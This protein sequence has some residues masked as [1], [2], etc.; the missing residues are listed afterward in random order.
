MPEQHL[1][2]ELELVKKDI[3]NMHSV[4]TKLDTAIDKLSEVATSL[5]KMLAVQE[6]R[7]DSH[8]RNFSDSIQIVHDRIEKHKLQVDDQIDDSYKELMQ[9]IRELKEAQQDHHHSVSD[10]LT[11]LEQWRF[12]MIGGAIVVGFLL[13]SIDIAKLFS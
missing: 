5:N 9:E 6:S 2:T 10:R 7:L 8:E 1:Q 3:T 11:K 13:S 12:V 4:M